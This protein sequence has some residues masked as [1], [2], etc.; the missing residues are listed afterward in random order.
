[1]FNFR[2]YFTSQLMMSDL[3]D[4]WL[5]L[6]FGSYLFYL[7]KKKAYIELHNLFLIWT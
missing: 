1:M 3:Y 5:F 6:P 4:L 7:F 2:R